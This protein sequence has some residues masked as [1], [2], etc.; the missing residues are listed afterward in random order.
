L[1]RRRGEE[2]LVNATIAC[3][4]LRYERDIVLARQRARQIAGAV[5]FETQDQTRFSTAVSEIARNAFE[6]GGGGRIEF[7]IEGRTV[8]QVL[9]VTIADEGKGIADVTAILEGRYESES[10][11]GIGMAGARR[12]VD[13]MDIRSEPG[14]GTVVTLKKLLPRALAPLTPADVGRISDA[15]ARERPRDAVEEVQRQNQELVQALAELTRR[16]EELTLLNR[17]LE[18]TNRGVVALYA[19]LDEKAD[20]LRRADEMKTRFISNMSHEF[21]TPVNSI[22]AL[23]QLLLDQVDGPLNLEQ[24]RQA[25]FIRKAADALSDLVNDLLDLAKVEAGKTVVRPTEFQVSTLFGTL[26]GM[27][28]PLLVNESVRLVFDADEGLPAMYTDEGKVSQILRNFVSNALK[29]T[30]RGEVR[31]SARLAEDGASVV[32]QVSDTGIGI[33]P[34]D[35]ER[36]F[37]EF[38]QI[39]HPLQRRVRGTGLGLPLCRRLADLLGGTVGVTSAVGVGSTFLAEIPV[40][41]PASSPASILSW[42]PHPDLLPVLV[43]EDEPEMLLLYEK[44]LSGSRYQMIGARTLREAREALKVTRPRAIVLDILLAG[45]DTWS[46]LAELK[47]GEETRAIPLLVATTVE[48]RAKALALGADLYLQKPVERTAFLWTLTRLIAPASVARV[49]IVDD[50]EIARYLLRQSLNS[51]HHVVL[52]AGGG[53]EGIRLAERELPDVVFLDLQMPDLNGYDVL[54]RLRESPLTREIPVVIFSS[55]AVTDEERL[56]LASAESIL[57]KEGLSGDRIRAAVVGALA[58]HGRSEAVS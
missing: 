3:L 1:H 20:H 51:T 34:D 18:D 17:E 21:R 32:F 43:V 56:V 6:Y 38:A 50:D 49:L 23:A 35:L 10:G 37:Q 30:E 26:R 9:A 4:V 40:Y 33:A 14:K 19:E 45:E 47:R 16:Q 42:E 39:E 57:H 25:S 15:L 27:L 11:M 24:E 29:F 8:P 55:H 48:D 22:Q 52:E 41:Y 44:H 12:L 13:R 53:F 36:I 46:L 58:S 31:V 54:R 2:R 7:A 28:R 5:G